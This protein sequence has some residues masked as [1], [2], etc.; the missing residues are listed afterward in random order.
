M[1]LTLPHK[2]EWKDYQVIKML[3]G[4]GG[5]ADL[6]NKQIKYVNMPKQT[7]LKH[8]RPNWNPALQRQGNEEVHF[9]A[10]ILL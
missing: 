5:Q 1:T 8:S 2:T 3:Q 7:S 4:A 9:T 6:N 10:V